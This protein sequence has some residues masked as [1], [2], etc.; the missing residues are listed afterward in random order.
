MIAYR[1]AELEMFSA[2]N[3]VNRRYK[4][5]ICWNRYEVKYPSMNIHFT[6]KVVDSK[7]PGHS[8][9]ISYVMGLYWAK[10]RRLPYA[11]WHVHGH[12]FEALFG[13]NP[14]AVIK[15][16]RVPKLI[17]INEGNWKDYNRG[18]SL[19]PAMASKCCDCGAVETLPKE[20]T[21]I[22]MFRRKIR[23]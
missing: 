2:L 20:G 17:S 19:Y 6:L 10:R 5:N 12:F 8:V 15:S 11:C 9:G 18:S 7:K 4:N 14:K 16:N 3:I 13:I 1:V 21:R 23:T 22:R